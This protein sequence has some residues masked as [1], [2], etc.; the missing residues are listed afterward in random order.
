GSLA[1]KKTV[2]S[3]MTVVNKDN[4]D[5]MVL[6]YSEDPGSKQSGGKIENFIAG[7]MVP[8]FSNF[9][10]DN[11]VGK[12]GY[13]QSDFGFHIIEVLE[14]KAAH[15]PN[16]AIVEKTLE[17]S[18]ETLDN[19]E[20]EATNLVLEFH[21]KISAKSSLRAKYVLFD[22]LASRKNYMPLSLTLDEKNLQVYGMK[23]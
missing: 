3:L 11:P 22:T 18:P 13:V 17:A 21:D 19:I 14:K 6:Q 15:I 1:K 4:F 20:G 5:A 2:D 10:R 23:T 9:A 8:E 12:I 7:E 16:L